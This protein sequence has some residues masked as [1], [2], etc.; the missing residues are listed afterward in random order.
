MRTLCTGPHTPAQAQPTDE[1]IGGALLP[2]I[3]EI[4]IYILC[5]KVTGRGVCICIVSHVDV[6]RKK[7]QDGV[8]SRIAHVV[9]RISS[10]LR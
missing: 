4:T 3:V 7:T 2:L 10:A 6:V 8:C 9:S 1:E 5:F